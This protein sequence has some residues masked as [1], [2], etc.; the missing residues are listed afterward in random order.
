MKKILLYIDNMLYGGAN[1]VMANLANHFCESEH[2]T[3]LV[4][5]RPYDEECPGYAINGSV[6]RYYLDTGSR[7]MLRRTAIRLKKLRKIIKSERPDVVLSFMAGP[8]TRMLMSTIGLPAKKVVSVRNDPYKE[9]GSGIKRIFANSLF[10]LA[11]G[12]VFQTDEAAE[13][14]SEGIQAKSKV[15]FNP[16]NMKFYEKQWHPGGHNIVV[17]GRLQSQKNPLLVLRAFAKIANSLSGITLDYVGEGKLKA[18][19]QDSAVKFGVSDRVHFL[20]KREDIDSILEQACIYV[21]CSD[22]EGMPN[23]LMEAMTVGIPVISTNCPCGGPRALIKERIQG[24]L[25]PCGDVDALASEMER[26]I[27]DKS[28]QVDMSVAERKRSEDFRPDRILA[29]WDSFLFTD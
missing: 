18:E 27:N 10:K 7:N 19:L 11:D 2:E 6:K 12:V 5:D 15:I 24:I 21:L 4:N 13:Y 1:R 17:V 26:L 25:V 29:E 23:A 9:Y 3:I 22:F 20:G 8:N 16:V 28:Y 14:F